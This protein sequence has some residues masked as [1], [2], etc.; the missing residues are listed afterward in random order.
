MS[1]K[2]LKQLYLEKYTAN[3]VNCY[4]LLRS[5]FY[6]EDAEKSPEPMAINGTTWSAV[7]KFFLDNELILTEGLMC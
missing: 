2:Q 7:K 4:D 3:R 1:P 5:F 6:F